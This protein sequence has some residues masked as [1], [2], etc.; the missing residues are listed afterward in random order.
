MRGS[1]NITMCDNQARYRFTW[2]GKDEAVIC[3]DHVGRLRG[4]ASAIGLHLQ[5]IPLSEE[6]LK[7]GLTCNQKG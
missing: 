7:T 6:D 1:V 5:V 4:L 3:E 2:P